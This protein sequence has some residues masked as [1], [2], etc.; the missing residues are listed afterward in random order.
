MALRDLELAIKKHKDDDENNILSELLSN[1]AIIEMELN[2]L[3]SPP[4]RGTH[5]F[6][7]GVE[8]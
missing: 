4:K 7:E 1:K 5:G 2:D 6:R 3:N 8:L